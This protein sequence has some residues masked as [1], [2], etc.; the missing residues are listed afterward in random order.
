M[1]E[2]RT[3]NPMQFFKEAGDAVGV[4][5]DYRP[6]VVKGDPE[7]ET[8][9]EVVTV[10]EVDHGEPARAE[11]V[12]EPEGDDE[13]SEFDQI[14]APTENEQESKSLDAPVLE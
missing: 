10:P 6:R 11:P 8:D 12:E 5:A 9:V 2:P 14:L 3:V 13:P 1:N 7:P 4:S